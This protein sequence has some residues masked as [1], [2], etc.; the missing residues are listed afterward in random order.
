MKR[1][2]R[3]MAENFYSSSSLFSSSSEMLQGGSAGQWPGRLQQH[4]LQHMAT[5]RRGQSHGT[6]VQTCSDGSCYVGEFKCGVKHGLGFYHFRNGDRYAGEYFA[7]KI[8]GFG[9]YHFANGHCY[10]GSW[11]ESRKQGFGTYVFRNGDSRSGEWDCGV[12][13]SPHPASDPSV[14]HAVHAARKAAEKAILLPRVDDQV[15]NAVSAAN[16]AA[17]AARVAAIKAV[18]NQ[19]NGKFYDTDV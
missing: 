13:K 17:I 2:G 6:G 12:L 3:D 8:H 16:R 7:D 15:N 19:T 18:Q 1:D 14:S 5:E 11:H 9:V 10:E 4:G